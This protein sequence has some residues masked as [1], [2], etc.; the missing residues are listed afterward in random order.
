[1]RRSIV[2]VLSSLVITA[3]SGGVVPVGQTAQELKTKSDGSP[4]GDGKTCSWEG[5][6]LYDGSSAATGAQLLGTDFPS[7]DGCNECSCSSHGIM[8]TLR[9]CEPKACP[10][11]AKQCPDGSYV[12]ATGPKCE[13]I[14][15]GGGTGDDPGTGTSPPKACSADARQCPDGSYVS[16]T[17]PNCEFAQCPPGTGKAC[18]QEALKCP[19]GSYVSRTGPNCEFTPCPPK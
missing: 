2:L 5:T 10:D 3:C 9:T 8:C 17:G 15:K 16:R 14:C 7:L 6:G 18:S 19:D 4:T 11:L 12:G 1:M 13:F